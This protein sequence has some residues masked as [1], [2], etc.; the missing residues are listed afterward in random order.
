MPSVDPITVE[1]IRNH[2][3]SSAQEMNRNLVRTSYNTIVYEIH[4]FGL[5]IYDRQGRL[6]AE[7][8]GLAIFT[9]GNDY[10]IRKMLEYLGEDGI[11]PA[12]LILLNYP[13]WSSR[14]VP[15]VLAS[16]PS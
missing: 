5:G 8:P 13:H 15:T 10:G 12:D 7:A 4:D 1:V 14:H 11:Q 9:R 6:L 2:L 16:S 3:L